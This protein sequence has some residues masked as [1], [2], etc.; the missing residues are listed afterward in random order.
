MSDFSLT[1]KRDA[2]YDACNPLGTITLNVTGNVVINHESVDM[3][4]ITVSIPH[5]EDG[6]DKDVAN[7]LLSD[8]KDL[9][10][11]GKESLIIMENHQQIYI[12]Y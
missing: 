2:V 11:N 3:S 12:A 1:G 5:E 4:S 9:T 6:D 10:L 8:I 7:Q